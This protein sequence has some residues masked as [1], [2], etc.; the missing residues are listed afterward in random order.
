MLQ[1]YESF[2][3]VCQVQDATDQNPILTLEGK[4]KLL[5]PLLPH[6]GNCAKGKF[7][8]LEASP[9]LRFESTSL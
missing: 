5:A 8:K 7:P 6:L 1:K 2:A 4:I 9:V 3:V